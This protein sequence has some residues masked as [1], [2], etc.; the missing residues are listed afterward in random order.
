MRIEFAFLAAAADLSR[1][2]RASALG[3][4]IPGILVDG[5]PAAIPSIAVVA[6]VHCELEECGIAHPIRITLVDAENVPT[7]AVVE[8]DMTI[9]IS[10]V[11]PELG[12]W[13]QVVFQLHGVRFETIGVYQFEIIV[14]NQRVGSIPLRVAMNPPA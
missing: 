13:G 8:T 10:P 7:G 9:G 2:G 1:D 5:L 3:L 14:D 4:G 11:M 6:Q 12:N